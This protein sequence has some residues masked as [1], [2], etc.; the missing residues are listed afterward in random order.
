[1]ALGELEGAGPGEGIPEGLLLRPSKVAAVLHGLLS[2]CPHLELDSGSSV[3]TQ[4]QRH[5]G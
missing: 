2:F 4:P 1:M 5:L 3:R